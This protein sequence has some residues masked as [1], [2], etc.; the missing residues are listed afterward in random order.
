MHK[1]FFISLISLILNGFISAQAEL[2][3]NF[4]PLLHSSKEFNTKLNGYGFGIDTEL[5]HKNNKKMRLNFGFIYS[6]YSGDGFTT[7]IDTNIPPPNA[8]TARFY[9]W[10]KRC[11]MWAMPISFKYSIIQFNNFELNL[12]AGI[13]VASRFY[14]V[15]DAT[16]YITRTYHSNYDPGPYSGRFDRSPRGNKLV[17]SHWSPLATIESIFLK[18]NKIRLVSRIMFSYYQSVVL[19]AGVGVQIF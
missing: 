17:P 9:S 16:Y 15:Y 3:L 13:L 14:S 11:K 10:E 18:G 6:D 5:I 19:N 2:K 1:V 8:N 4:M 12:G 7:K